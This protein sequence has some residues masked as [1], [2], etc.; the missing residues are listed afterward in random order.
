M[1]IRPLCYEELSFYYLIRRNFG[2]D[3]IWRRG[4]KKL[5]RIFDKFK[6]IRTIYKYKRRLHSLLSLI[7][8]TKNI[9]FGQLAYLKKII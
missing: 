5:V 3:L 7:T 1:F 8:F 2:A 9:F 6:E 4:K